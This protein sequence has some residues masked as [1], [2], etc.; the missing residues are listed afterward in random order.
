MKQTLLELTIDVLDAI[1]GDEVNSISDSTESLQI[2]NL[3]KNVYYDLIGRKDW[4]FLRKLKSFESVGDL[5]RPTHLR[6]PDNTSK[7]E[8]LNYNKRK[9]LNSRNFYQPIRFR[10]PDEFLHSVNQR[11]NTLSNY[12]NVTD[13]DGVVL[14][15]RTDEQPSFFTSFD[16]KYIVMDSY[17][18][19][20]E[21]TLQG[22]NTQAALF[23]IPDWSVDDNFTP[24][25][26]AEMFP[27]F[28]AECK[29]YA[30]AKNEDN[31]SQKTEQ[32]AIRHQRH[33]SQTHGVVQ[34]GVRYPNYGR[35][36]RKVSS[37]STRSPLFG[38]LS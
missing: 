30:I 23:I 28:L 1:D 34:G 32:T 24:D 31:L 3:I 26:P 4:Q 17:D 9:V 7:L 25:L 8:F 2:S 19:A 35:N 13:F 18:N 38:P 37:A 10:Y 27:Q 36:P 16:D 29:T 6:I 33:L 12:V 15:I 14:T 21:A 11:D 20:V 5:A 22:S